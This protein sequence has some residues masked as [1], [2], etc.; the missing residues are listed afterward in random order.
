MLKCDDGFTVIMYFHGC[1]V[2][3]V[4]VKRCNGVFTTLE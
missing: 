1:D 2:F 3:T 4:I